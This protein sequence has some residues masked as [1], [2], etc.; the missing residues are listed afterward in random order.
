MLGGCCFSIKMVRYKVSAA[1]KG[2]I[3]NHEYADCLERLTTIYFNNMDD[4]FKPTR[5]LVT[6]DKETGPDLKVDLKNIKGREYFT[7]KNFQDCE[8]KVDTYYEPSWRN[9]ESIDSLFTS[10]KFLYLIQITFSL[11]HPAK[12]AVIGA[13]GKVAKERHSD[14]EGYVLILVLRSSRG[15]EEYVK[16]LP[17]NPM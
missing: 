4:I 11:R 9:L 13:V 1:A 12:T 15:G 3:E 14:L 16:D 10:R 5:K 6:P 17:T 7:Q 8:F 2:T